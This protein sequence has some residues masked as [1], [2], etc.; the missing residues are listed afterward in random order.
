MSRDS[1]LVA[2][3]DFN[4]TAVINEPQVQ[5]VKMFCP[6][7]DISE[8]GELFYEADD[9]GRVVFIGPPLK[10]RGAEHIYHLTAVEENN[11]R[12]LKFTWGG[13][14]RRKESYALVD[15]VPPNGWLP[16]EFNYRERVAN[17]AETNYGN[18]LMWDRSRQFLSL[19]VVDPSRRTL[20][21][22]PV[23]VK[24]V[25]LSMRDQWIDLEPLQ[26]RYPM[27]QLIE[28]SLEWIT[29]NPFIS[30][31]MIGPMLPLHGFNCSYCGGGLGLDKCHF[32]KR[33]VCSKRQARC[34]WPYPIPLRVCDE[35]RWMGDFA[36]SPANAMKAYYAQW[37]AR[38]FQ[39]PPTADQP[40]DVR[41]IVLRD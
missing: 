3:R 37:A 31:E 39:S 10:I 13:V 27:P 24:Q 41:S 2:L 32:C 1:L 4:K 14:Y 21:H 22:Y 5:H 38:D 19:S 8:I 6:H 40:R 9:T 11:K 33:P 34:D 35:L 23:V 12:V 30:A 25:L 18:L 20:H 26:D 28:T 16:R 29:D 7:L 15:N 17:W 36:T